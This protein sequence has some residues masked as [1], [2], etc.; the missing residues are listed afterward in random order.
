MFKDGASTAFASSSGVDQTSFSFTPDD[1]GSYQIVL[2]VSDEDGGS[3]TVDQTISVANVAPTP[4]ITTISS[5]QQEGTAISVTGAASDPAGANDTL[6]YSWQVFKNGAS[7]AFASSSGVDQTSFSF[8]PDDDGSYRI[9]LSVS[10]EDG[11]STTVDQTISVANV[12]PTPAIATISNV[13]QEGTAISVTGTASDPAGSSDTLT[14]AWQVFKDGASTAFASSSGIDQTSFSFTPDDDGSY[15]I[16]LTVSDEDGGSTTV[17]QTISVANMAPTVNVVAP[18]DSVRGQTVFLAG[19][20]TDPGVLDTHTVAINWGDG[21]VD[22]PSPSSGPITGS[23]IYAAAGQYDISVTV[24]DNHGDQTTVESSIVVSVVAI[25][26][27][28]LA[29]G[30]T[31]G[32]DDIQFSPGSD[33]GDIEVKLNGSSLGV[34]QPT[35]RLYAYGQ[36]GDDDIQVA[37]GISV[38]A[39]LFGDDGDDRLKGGKGHDVLFG[40][41]GD[42]L[43]VGQSG[44]D[45]LVGG[46]GA[47]RIVGNADE[48]LLVA[49]TLLL[50]ERSDAIDAIMAEWTSSRDF[51]TRVANI[52]GKGEGPR[53]NGDYF[54]V[55]EG[56]EANIIDDGAKDTLTGAAGLDWFFA[57]LEEGV[58]DKITDLHDDE[59]ADDLE[60]IFGDE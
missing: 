53:L 42:D 43:L 54:L 28:D 3:A 7:T 27:N 49:G 32:A 60:F 24:V 16:V 12:A 47:D 26:G 30:G 44:R 21:T 6:T 11:G 35:G 20:F 41:A 56:N 52:Q 10:D 59:F 38:S 2:T 46:L 36:G 57:T 4:V 31:T 14:Y 34:F 22:G 37:G 51:S 17:D 48:D 45:L 5:P 25:Q 1:N 55:A 8:T 40:G 19:D 29:V 15:Q 33:P 50:S 13:R 18:S 39:W 58:L 23:H 9:V